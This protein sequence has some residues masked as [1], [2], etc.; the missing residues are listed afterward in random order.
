MKNIFCMLGMLLF[1]AGC[2]V[3]PTVREASQMQEKIVVY[4]AFK[5]EYAGRVNYTEEDRC[6]SVGFKRYAR[7]NEGMDK[8]V[9]IVMEETCSGVKCSCSYSGIG[10]KYKPMDL[11]EA[12]RWESAMSNMGVNESTTKFSSSTETV[13]NN[14]YTPPPSVNYAP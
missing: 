9:D 4:S 12:M 14:T 5:A 3:K 7:V 11:N 2:A 6:D 8:V 10:L 13:V 1:V